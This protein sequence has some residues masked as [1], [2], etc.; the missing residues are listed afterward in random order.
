MKKL[1][2]YIKKL[3]SGAALLEAI[4]ALSAVVVAISG[5]AVVVTAS[6]SNSQFIQ[7]Q[8]NANKYAQEG[9]E[10]LKSKKEESFSKFVGNYSGINEA[11]FDQEFT[12]SIDPSC[13]D[14]RLDDGKFIRK[15]TVQQSDSC[16]TNPT[17]TA[18]LAVVT[19]EW[20]SSKCN[21]ATNPFC[22][23]SELRTC[24]AETGPSNVSLDFLLPDEPTSTPTPTVTNTPTPTVTNTPT[25]TPIPV[26]CQTRGEICGLPALGFGDCCSGLTCSPKMFGGLCE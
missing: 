1:K 22:H 19:V 25:P 21:V 8:N 6:L 26:D 12:T 18:Y 5:I 9:M 3:Q 20:Q 24:F 10:Y 17:E 14:H 13:K 7:D 11:C 2:K 4:V 15:I 16:K 23:K